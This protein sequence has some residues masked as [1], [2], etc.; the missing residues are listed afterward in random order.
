MLRRLHY[1]KTAL[2]VFGAGMIAGLVVVAGEYTAW[3]RPA[4]ALMA[5]GLV[6]IPIGLFAD[7]HGMAAL[8]WLAARLSR[9]R[10]PPKRGKARPP[11]RRPKRTARAA[12]KSPPRPR[13]R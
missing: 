4:A 2:L 10:P 13:R 9:R 1:T 3:Q 12:A 11:A 7:G 8:S 6:L 5:L